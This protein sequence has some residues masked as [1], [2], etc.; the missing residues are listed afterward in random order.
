M[1]IQIHEGQWSPNRINPKKI[2]PRHII[3]NSQKSKTERILKATKQKQLIT[4]KGT[5][6]RPGRNFSQKPCW[7]RGSDI[8]HNSDDI[9]NVLKVQKKKKGQEY[10]TWQN[11]PSVLKE[12]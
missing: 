8:S 5:P 7:S 1:D 10:Y 2:T 9:F 6:I 3:T 11:Y 4:Y 12:K